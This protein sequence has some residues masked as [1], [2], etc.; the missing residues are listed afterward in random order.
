MNPHPM[1][2]QYNQLASFS[3]AL[4]D[5]VRDEKLWIGFD[6]RIKQ[7]S[8]YDLHFFDTEGKADDFKHYNSLQEKQVSL[9]PVVATLYFLQEAARNSLQEG[10]I[11][12]NIKLDWDKVLGIYGEL[13]FN[14]SYSNLEELMDR[15][16]WS[17]IL[18]DPLEAN[19][20]AE[21]FE[22]KV[23][24]N[25]LEFLVEQ[26]SSFALTGEKENAFVT[27][28][29]NKHWKD[30]PMEVQI[31]D[32]LSGRYAPTDQRQPSPNG[33]DAFRDT[34]NKIFE[35]PLFNHSKTNVMNTDNFEYLQ[36]QLKYAGFGEG[37]TTL[38]EKNLKEGLPDFELHA[39][40]EFGKDKMDAVLYF[41]KS[42]QEGKDMYFFNKYDAT[43]QN[44]AGNK[45]QTF[46]INNK[47]QSITFKEACNLLNN[48]SVYKEVT[49]KEGAKYKAWIKLDPMNRDKNG[50]PKFKYYNENNG[51]D[52]KE[53][54]GRIPLKEISDPD[55]MESLYA[56]LQ[57][58][59]VAQATLIKGDKEVKVQVAADP[60]FKTLKLYDMEG[61]KLFM[62][63]P[64]QEQQFGMAPADQKKLEN[65]NTLEAGAKLD[66]KEGDTVV[67][68]KKRDLLPKKINNN[69]LLP[70]KRTQK[71]KGKG[72]A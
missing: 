47:G 15:F 56:S 9:F 13:K 26:L 69:P 46:F 31:A 11:A 44:D 43:L 12:P 59:N 16:D 2:I 52:L 18:Y 60:Q 71:T 7:L 41:K 30:Q 20:E 23:E 25:R 8:V 51:F 32:V 14:D 22:D 55:R 50:N 29:V 40:H 72:I 36:S 39:A 64:K 58:G 49:P 24:F 34:H 1:T 37:L 53:A 27:A 28:L 70:K 45:S 66:I 33:G 65:G 57:K 62:P 19:T 42:E 10:I 63:G 17:R 54:V 38:L 21:S 48:R 61:K 3:K 6:S 67:M 68:N 4:E 35:Q 5:A